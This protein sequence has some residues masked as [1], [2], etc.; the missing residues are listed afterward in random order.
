MM[1]K[2]AAANPKL[3][4]GILFFRLSFEGRA[5]AGSTFKSETSLT[6][7]LS[8]AKRRNGAIVVGT[9]LP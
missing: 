7:Y 1:I 8:V 2:T 3:S 4:M 9:A 5:I 6:G